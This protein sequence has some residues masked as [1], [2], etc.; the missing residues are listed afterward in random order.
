MKDPLR[1]PLLFTSASNHG[2]LAI[3]TDEDFLNNNEEEQIQQS[4]EDDQYNA[5]S[6]CCGSDEGMNG[7]QC[8][9]KTNCQKE[10]SSCTH[11]VHDGKPMSSGCC[12]KSCCERVHEMESSSKQQPNCC[13]GE[14]GDNV[15]GSSYCPTKKKIQ[16]SNNEEGT[17]Q[18]L[19]TTTSNLKLPSSTFKKRNL[20]NTKTIT[21]SM[22]NK[23][24]H[25]NMEERKEVAKEEVTS[26]NV[27]SCCP[28][29]ITSSNN[30]N[31]TKVAI[32]QEA[33]VASCCTKSGCTKK[34]TSHLNQ[35][36]TLTEEDSKTSTTTSL[37]TSTTTTKTVSG[38]TKSCC[39]KTSSEGGSIST[40]T[41]PSLLAPLE[42]SSSPCSKNTSSCCTSG[43]CTKKSTSIQ[44]LDHDSPTTV[45][46]NMKDS[47]STILHLTVQQLHCSDCAMMVEETL[48]KRKG[49]LQARV[50]DITNSARIIYDCTTIGEDE[51]IEHI[52]RLGYP[53]RKQFVPVGDASNSNG[54]NDF[55]TTMNNN[56]CAVSYYFQQEVSSQQITQ[57]QQGLKQ[58]FGSALS[59]SFYDTQKRILTVHYDPDETGARSLKVFISHRY[60]LS[61][62]LFNGGDP[63]GGE[64]SQASTAIQSELE[65]WKRNLGICFA[66][67][68]PIMLLV[69][70]VPMMKELHSYLDQEIIQGL[71]RSVLLCWLLATP[72]QFYFGK[73]LYLSAY[74][75]LRYA[76]KP[77][78]DALVMLSTTTAYLYSVLNVVIAFFLKSYHA[79]VFFETSAMLLTFII[80]GRFLE[81]LAKGQTSNMLSKMMELKVSRALWIHTQAS[82]EVNSKGGSSSSLSSTTTTTPIAPTTTTITTTTT[83]TSSNIDVK[84]GENSH[85]QEHL[86]ELLLSHMNSMHSSCT[87]QQHPVLIEEEIDIHLVQ[88]GDILK[89]LPGSKIPTDGMVIH[90]TTSVDE[91]MISGEPLPVPK[92]VRDSVFGSTINQNGTIYMKVTKIASENTLSAIDKLIRESQSSK[93]PIQRIADTVS[94]YFVPIIM[95]MSG[96]AFVLWISLAYGGVLK[97]PENMHPFTFALQF[98]LAILV[99]SCPCAISLA[100]PTAI[101]VGIGVAAKFGVLVKSGQVMEMCH[102]V[103]CV[104]F[105]KTGT[106]T[107]GKPIVTNVEILEEHASEWSEEQFLQV[108]GSAELGSEHLLGKAI[109]EHVQSLNK[110]IS[111]SHPKDYVAEPGK[112]LTCSVTIHPAHPSSNS[113]GGYPAHPSS[114]S[115]EGIS[116][117]VIAGHFD[118][119]KEHTFITF[120]QSFQ[121][122]IHQLENEGKTVVCVVIQSKL[123][124]MIALADTPKEEASL[125]VKELKKRGMDVWMISGD[126]PRTVQYIASQIGIDQFIG[127]V[128]PAEKAQKVKELQNGELQLSSHNEPLSNTISYPRHDNN[129]SS[130]NNGPLSTTISNHENHDGKDHPH[131]KRVRKVLMVGDGLNDG[132]A[133]ATADVGIAIGAGCDVAL[134]AADVVLVK[135]DLKDVLVA[136]DLSKTT[137]QRIKMNFVWAFFYNLIGIPLAA[138]ALYPALGVVIP[139]ALAGLSEIFSSLPVVLFS[140]LLK[141]FKPRSCISSE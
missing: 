94:A 86:Q 4:L 68:C 3:S 24:K 36:V 112:G 90:G 72:I 85:S 128:L 63:Q 16:S 70:V 80:L 17:T 103:N 75:A 132:A 129:N 30:N 61:I 66:L 1:R 127:G 15:Q 58:Q 98:A 49:V 9:D 88:R 29:D 37:T 109:V 138:G 14:G 115:P 69:F 114:N 60:G 53:T 87:S 62:S 46:I 26:K 45:V 78:M 31:N 52:E 71:S 113:S 134:E 81:I 92:R 123:I 55:G 43:K 91:S 95:I 119:I 82:P 136:L 110:G 7:E 105:D 141:T 99:I 106:L 117:S 28:N 2:Q 11:E 116:Y 131:G 40:N 76:R 42:S 96:L 79:E 13:S 59:G 10:S 41:Q 64:H 34:N 111:L 25:Q 133:L 5:N 101:M 120:S 48:L 137:F 93:V 38:C 50:M 12:S 102:K 124:G 27:E 83:T 97:L 33:T 65:L 32:S 135:S 118:F 20:L 8:T 51:I 21:L 18:S 57:L 22:L 54:S 104:I 47:K 74:R 122:R 19:S 77:N 140:L 56:T 84:V 126:N 107:H 139:P 44:E 6:K 125:V 23:T 89:V 39:K 67:C 108:I 121:D 130:N 100:S 35:M 73:P